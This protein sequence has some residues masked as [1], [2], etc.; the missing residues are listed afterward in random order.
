M[1]YDIEAYIAF[2]AVRHA[3]DLCRRVQA[4]LVTEDTLNKK[5]KSPVTVADFGSQALISKSLE[6]AFPDDPLVAEEDAR[7]LRDP[8]NIDT[9]RKVVE[10]VAHWREHMTAQEILSAIDRGGHEGGRNGRFWCLDPIDGTKGFL[11]GEQY[12]IALALIENGHPVLGVL[13]CPNLPLN[14]EQ[15]GSNRGC[16]FVAVHGEGAEMYALDREETHRVHVSE[17]S[18]PAESCFCESVESGHSSHDDSARIAEK[19][20]VTN[21]PFRIDSQCK[22]AAVARADASI[23]LRLPTRAGYQE[24]IW[25]HAAGWMIVTEGGGRVTDTRGGDLDFSRGRKLERNL[26][27]VATNGRLHEAVIAAVKDVLGAD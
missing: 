9:E 21:P 20:G 22:Y 23:Y 10:H 12:A 17:I 8:Q 4:E 3:C 26:G 7:T 24:K 18:D 6:E 25:D 16:L 5:D 27:V 19:L 1:A 11:R 2:E 13:G 14:A 15:P